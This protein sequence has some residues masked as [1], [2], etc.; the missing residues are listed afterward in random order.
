[1]IQ[2]RNLSLAALIPQTPNTEINTG[3]YYDG[4]PVYAQRFTASNVSLTARV[5]KEIVL[6]ASGIKEPL[7]AI[8]WFIPV[9]GAAKSLVGASFINAGNPLVADGTS[10]IAVNTSNGLIIR[11]IFSGASTD[12]SYDFTVYYTKI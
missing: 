11:V 10:Y 1:M 9:A 6:I 2:A 8:G 5:R 12:A 7:H 4:R 3:L